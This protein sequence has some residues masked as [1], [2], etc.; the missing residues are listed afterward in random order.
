VRSEFSQIDF[1]FRHC[2]ACG[3][4]FVA[5]ARE[6]FGALYDN[7]YYEGRGADTFVDYI[8]EMGN[9]DSIREYEW[10]GIVRAVEQLTAARDIKWLDYG[11]GLGG[12]VRYARAHGFNDVFGY[13]DGFS[14]QWMADHD[15]PSLTAA[16]L[17][18]LEGQFDVITAIEV[19][20]HL[21]DPVGTMRHIASLLKP[22]GHFFATTGNAEPHRDRL[23]KW[24]YIH[25]DVHVSYFEPRTLAETYR[26]AGL[27]PKPGRFLPG[28]DDIIRYKVLKTMGIRNRNIVERL[29]P[30]RLASRVVDRRHKV[31][32]QPSARR[33]A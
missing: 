6:D 21:T 30:W 28:H 25:P 26:R 4:S 16:Q 18:D 11:C 5:N 13:D 15:I 29:V 9:P 23:A 17:G 1:D 31:S 3:L 20:E 27:E 19:L 12:L 2:R 24:S 22:G 32:D 8:A 7:E 14:A 33:P 10:R